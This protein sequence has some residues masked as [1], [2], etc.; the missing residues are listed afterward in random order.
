MGDVVESF[1]NRLHHPSLASI[2]L[3]LDRMYRFLS[4]LGSPDKRLPPVIHVAGT[5]GKGS[6]IAYLQS[7][8]QAAGYKVH[9]YTSPHL[10]HFQERIVL[11]GQEIDRPYLETILKH[12]SNLL[13]T[14]PATFFEATTAAAFLAFSER[15][16]DVL[17][18]ETGMGGRLDATNVIAKPLLTA[19][20]PISYDHMEYLGNTLTAIAGEK[21][22]IMRKDIQCVVGKQ[23]EEAENVLEQKSTAL[24]TPLYRYG[25]EWQ[26]ENAVYH[27]PKRTLTLA[28]SLAGEYQFDNAAT[29]AAC[30]DLLPQFTITDEHIAQG[31]ANAK[32]PARLQNLTH[33]KYRDL[34]P[35]GVELW[36]DG[37]HNPQGGEVL[38]KWLKERN[39]PNVYFICGMIRGKDPTAFLKS[40]KPYATELYAVPITGENLSRPP[41]EVETAAKSLGIQSF[42]SPSVENALQTIATHA[43]TPAIVCI[44]GSLYL[45]GKVLAAGNS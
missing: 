42:S 32:W 14:Q 40:L 36:L 30:I 8:F 38:G 20:T 10:V 39:I 15:K 44:C 4:M 43:K 1:L 5:N 19:I 7:I 22:G 28:P 3:S 26:V 11:A 25:K 9:R 2:D 16:A 29:A 6:L 24:G 17:L 41:V 23:V 31:L 27:S 45:A 34:L 35:E 18:M 33:G 13:P 21:A 37:G 12:V